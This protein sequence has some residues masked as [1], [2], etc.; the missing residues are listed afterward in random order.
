MAELD[1]IQR[2]AQEQF[3]RQSAR[4]GKGH[5]LADTSDLESLLQH[6]PPL[7]GNKALDVATGGGHAGLYLASRGWQVTLADISAAMLERVEAA[8]KE[9]GLSVET[10]QHPAESFPY[11]D[12]TFDLVNCRVAPHH[13]SDPAAFVRESARVLKPGGAFTLVDG[14]IEDD[15][16]VAEAWLHDVEKLR[17][18]SHNRLLSPRTWKRLCEQAGLQV[19]HV[20]VTLLKQP[21]IDWYFET[22]ATPPENRARIL[23][24]VQEAPPEAKALFRLAE[25]DR[26]IVWW[27]QRLSL[28]A[29]KPSHTA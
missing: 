17:D 2:S 8:A 27:W 13:F 11:P 21:D 25:E 1:S 9:R 16:P 19:M 18:P 28:L 29:S 5:I 3:D 4:Y 22:A 12:A 26:K 20:S 15:Q 23:K 14:T 10:R 7:P 6:L 24:L